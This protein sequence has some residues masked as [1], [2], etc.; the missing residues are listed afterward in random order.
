MLVARA[1]KR[2]SA[3]VKARK[4]TAL[5]IGL[6]VERTCTRTKRAKV[7]VAHDRT[8]TNAN[9]KE[10]QKKLQATDAKDAKEKFTRARLNN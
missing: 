10:R 2:A 3:Q 5:E 4:H 1:N 6:P 8:R 9:A 7:F